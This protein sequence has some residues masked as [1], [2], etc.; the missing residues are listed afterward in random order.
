[1]E[2]SMTISSIT[3]YLEGTDI[4]PPDRISPEEAD[5]IEQATTK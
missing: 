5:A 3:P 1:M 2:K 4:R